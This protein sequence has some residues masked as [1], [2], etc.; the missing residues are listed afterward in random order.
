MDEENMLQYHEKNAWNEWSSFVSGRSVFFAPVFLCK[1]AMGVTFYELRRRAFLPER[2]KQEI[3]EASQVDRVFQR[4]F[5][6][7]GYV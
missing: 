4:R 5:W 6:R 3:L 1:K 2:P 7:I